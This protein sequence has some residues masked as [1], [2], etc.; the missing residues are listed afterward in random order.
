M[1]LQL[2]LSFFFL[3]STPQVIPPPPGGGVRGR[4]VRGL[5]EVTPRA[6]ERLEV[7]SQDAFVCC[8]FL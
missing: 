6:A 5:A 3:S 1:G 7:E 8:L 4:R 2:A